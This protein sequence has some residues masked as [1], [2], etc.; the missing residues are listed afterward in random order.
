MDNTEQ[1]QT[2][3]P[4]H[5]LQE[6]FRDNLNTAISNQGLQLSPHAS[7]YVVN[8]LTLYSRSE[9]LYRDHGDYFGLKPLALMLRDSVDAESAAQRD[10]TLRRLGDVAL[11]MSGFFADSLQ[12]K[13]VDI[14]Y[15]IAMGGNAYSSL[16]SSGNSSRWVSLLAD[17]YLE[18]ARKFQ[19][20]VDVLHEVS[21]TARGISEHNMARLV[22][23]WRKTGSPRAEKLLNE[24]G[25]MPA[26]APVR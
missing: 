22:E 16:S 12:E 5:N 15:Y 10:E 20:L 13:S 1:S 26:F 19:Y 24:Q 3:I 11:F 25:V 8:L 21:D 23:I 9:A 7:H 14:D 6:F 4:V 17:V 18:L 2:I